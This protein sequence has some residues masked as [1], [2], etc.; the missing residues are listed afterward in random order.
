MPTQHVD[1]SV[2]AMAD[3]F[4]R[5]TRSAGPGT[6]CSPSRVT[7]R[8][9]YEILHAALQTAGRRRAEVARR[10]H[11]PRA[12]STRAS[13]SRS[14]A[15]SGRSRS[16]SIP[17]IDHRRGVAGGRVRASRSGSGRWRRSS[18]TSTGRAQIFADGVVP[19]RVVTTVPHFHRE[20]PGIDRANGVR[21]V[22]LRHRPDP[23]R[24]RALPGAGGQRP[25]AV[26]GVLRDGEPAGHCP[27]AARGL[28]RPAGPAG[29]AT[30]RAG[31]SP[32]CARPPRA[33]SPTRPSWCSPRASTTRPTSSTPCWPARWASSWS[34]AATCSAAATGSTM[35]TTAGER[36]C[37]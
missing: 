30:T 33:A 12:S 26:R 18:P 5:T 23:R 11:G 36:R 27:G 31:C 8:P 29:R 7:I 28:R 15:W 1:P 16:T 25:G 21:I 22:R 13:P 37:T 24:G 14:A 2:P 19:R 10:H 6:R 34:R 17:R 4:S 3:L 20:A 9:A 32:R 35:R